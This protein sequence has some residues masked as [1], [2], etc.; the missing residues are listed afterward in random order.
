MAEL[1]S[2]EKKQIESQDSTDVADVA[3]VEEVGYGEC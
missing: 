1:T 3:E 2:D